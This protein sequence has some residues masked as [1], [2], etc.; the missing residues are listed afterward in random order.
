MLRKHHS[1][2]FKHL[3]KVITMLTLLVVLVI[4]P[5][6]NV[7]AETTILRPTLVDAQ[8]TFISSAYPDMNYEN[9]GLISIGESTQYSYI[10]YG[11]IRFDISSLP[12]TIDRAVLQLVLFSSDNPLDEGPNTITAHQILTDWDAGTVTWNTSPS[13]DNTPAAS[14]KGEVTSAAIWEWDVTNLYRSWKTG[15][16]NYG[17][18]L[19]SDNLP[20]PAIHGFVACHNESPPD[21]WPRLVVD[22]NQIASYTVTFDSRGG[23]P[24]AAA[25]VSE[26]E[27]VPEPEDP[28]QENYVFDKWTQDEDGTMDWDF[29]LNSVSSDL[30]LY[31]QWIAEQEPT[32]DETVAT[33]PQ[34]TDETTDT[35]QQTTDE[36]TASTQ[37]TTHETTGTPPQSSE[38][39]AE[40][41]N[42]IPETGESDEQNYWGYS[43]LLTAAFVSLFA[44]RKRRVNNA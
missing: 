27:L 44:W 10:D 29:S 23:S 21:W 4:S 36:T 18:F 6:V 5:A 24:V 28:T 17:L 41:T 33:E 20:S 35:E 32:T 30:T 14:C 11:L 7:S 2:S 12:G 40:P 19:K 31:A 38:K 42:D 34:S 3:V 15:T 8:N 26:G 22:Y 43:L 37:A 39:T 25:T 9:N 16:V 1:D 13:Y